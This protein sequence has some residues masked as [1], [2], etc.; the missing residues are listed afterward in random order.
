MGI[1]AD[2]I[3]YGWPILTGVAAFMVMVASLLL[4]S[5]FVTR[6][7]H[8]LHAEADR[9]RDAKRDEAI[10]AHDREIKLLTQHLKEPPTRHELDERLSTVL[11]RLSSVEAEMRSNSLRI[12]REF[13]SLSKQLGTLN[14]YLQAIIEQGMRR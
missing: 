9:E 7:E 3:K 12:D 1:W 4:N 11:Q 2:Y 14:D 13:D 6:A 8:K 5:R 10:E